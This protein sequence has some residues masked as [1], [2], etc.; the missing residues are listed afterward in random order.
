MGLKNV[1]LKGQKIEVTYD[2]IQVSLEDIEQVIENAYGG[3][4]P[5]IVESLRRGLIHNSEECELDNLE[6]LSPKNPWNPRG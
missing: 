6:H 4:K 5:G 3:L 2:L 1:D